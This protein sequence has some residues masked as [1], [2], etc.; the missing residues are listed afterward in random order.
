MP[1]SAST[2]TLFGE[3]AFSLPGGPA[4]RLLFFD[5]CLMVCS[6]PAQDLRCSDGLGGYQDA[7]HKH[8]YDEQLH[9]L[10][11]VAQPRHAGEYLIVVG[12]WPVFSFFGNGP[13]DV[14]IR[15]LRPVLHRLRANLYLCGHDH[16]LQ[17]V[18]TADP[19]DPAFVVS[20]AGG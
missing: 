6:G 17:L 2:G 18:R 8:R 13:T 10:E 4:V 7:A 12:H 11:R 14:L 5:A 9:F 1:Q 19:R 20:G 16:V 3:R 15:N